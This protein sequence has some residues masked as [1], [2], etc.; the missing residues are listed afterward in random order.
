MPVAQLPQRRQEVRRRHHL[1]AVG[2][3]G[4]DHDRR[5]V[6][7][8]RDRAEGVALDVLEALQRAAVAAARPVQAPVRIGIRHLRDMAAADHRGLRLVSGQRR[9]AAGGAVVA[10]DERDQPAPAGGERQQPRQ[11]VV[12]VGA[13]GAEP[14]LLLELSGQQRAQ[15]LREL[16]RAG[17]RVA[18]E[19][20][21]VLAVERRHDRVAHR[22]MPVARLRDAA[23][24][25]HVEVAP[26]VR[27]GHADAVR[28]GRAERV[29]ADLEDVGER[30]ILAL[31]E[32]V[33]TPGGGRHTADSGTPRDVGQRRRDELA[34][35]ATGRW[36][37]TLAGLSCRSATAA[38]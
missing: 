7:G 38:S 21:R 6:R 13:G 23:R 34:R 37:A 11:A 29:E 25:G 27:V 19:H 14:G 1:A 8:R 9:R 35:R 2:L 33:G 16:G 3:H 15:P 10:A 4:L 22:R 5:R 20:R 28:R 32:L 24:S 17:I 30:A 26:A 31:E 36:R 12:R 18:A